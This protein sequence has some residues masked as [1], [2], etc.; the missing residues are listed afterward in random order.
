MLFSRYF[1][2][3]LSLPVMLAGSLSCSDKPDAMNKVSGSLLQQVEMRRQ[4][5]ASPSEQRL[6]QMQDMGMDTSDVKVQRV[7]IYLKETL[8]SSQEKELATMGV[9]IHPDTWIPP[10]GNNPTGFLIAEIPVDKLETLARADFI[11][12]LD[13]AEKRA[14]PN[15][16]G[17]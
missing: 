4:Q 10:V 3:L 7:F 6:K 2:I 16:C 17:Q 12:R 9:R 14:Y 11:V 15:M 1:A 8:T 5:V 13:T